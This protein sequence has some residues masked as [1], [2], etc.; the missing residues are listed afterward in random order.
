MLLQ[1]IIEKL[2]KLDNKVNELSIKEEAHIHHEKTVS[3]KEALKQVQHKNK[4]AQ[5]QVLNFNH[6]LKQIK[7]LNWL[8]ALKQCFVSCD[9]VT[10]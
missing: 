1:W 6:R 10:K 5:Q 8:F 4:E 2:D 9:F 7:I 3:K